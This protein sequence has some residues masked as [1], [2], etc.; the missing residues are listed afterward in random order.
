MAVRFLSQLSLEQQAAVCR[1]MNCISFKPETVCVAISLE[2]VSV[3][4]RC[5]CSVAVCPHRPGC[6]VQ[7][8]IREGDPVEDTASF[9][10]ILSGNVKVFVHTATS[11]SVLGQEVATLSVGEVSS[12]MQKSYSNGTRHTHVQRYI[13]HYYYYNVRSQSAQWP[14]QCGCCAL[15]SLWGHLRVEYS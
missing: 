15:L 13:M 8:L 5:H 2:L 11:T 10:I 7:C 1:V 14:R 9:F 12:A 4:T 6:V 3:G